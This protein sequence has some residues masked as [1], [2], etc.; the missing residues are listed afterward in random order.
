MGNSTPVEVPCTEDKDCE[1]MQICDGDKKICKDPVLVTGWNSLFA[2]I[3]AIAAPIV[4]YLLIG[5]HQT[6]P[7]MFEQFLGATGLSPTFAE[8]I[9]WDMLVKTIFVYGPILFGFA[10]MGL[11]VSMSVG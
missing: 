11:M 10:Y 4:G 5:S 7:K 6:L 9:I 2:V 1:D 8:W 3:A